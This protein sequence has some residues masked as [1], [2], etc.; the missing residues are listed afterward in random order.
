MRNYKKQQ[1]RAKKAGVWGWV[2]D[3]QSDR[4][5]ESGPTGNII[6]KVKDRRSKLEQKAARKDSH[7]KRYYFKQRNQLDQI[8]HGCG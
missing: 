5:Y 4:R 2:I 6:R 3:V 8:Q 7:Q 1:E